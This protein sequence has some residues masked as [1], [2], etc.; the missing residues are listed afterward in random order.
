[1]AK[2]KSTQQTDYVAGALIFSGRAD[3]VW[4]LNES[5]SSGL[6]TIWN[7]MPRYSGPTMPPPAH[8]YRGCFM[9]A[10]SGSEWI[11]Y[12]GVVSLKTK[13]GT[14]QRRD[15]NRQ[16]ERA[17]IKTAPAGTLPPQ[18]LLAEFD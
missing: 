6:L 13:A 18:F 8:G 1:M 5:T 4:M 9:C 3:P 17:L 2:P 10:P 16:F 7:S 12:R 14:D 15:D 11:A